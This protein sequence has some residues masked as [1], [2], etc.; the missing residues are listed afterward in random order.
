MGAGEGRGAPVGAIVAFAVLMLAGAAAVVLARRR[1]R[2]GD[3][4]DEEDGDGPDG[5][6]PAETGQP[7]A[8]AREAW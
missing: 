4:G 1:R 6:G 3:N 7:A 8:T 5:A 2:L